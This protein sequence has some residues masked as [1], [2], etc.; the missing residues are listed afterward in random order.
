MNEL[1]ITV[2]CIQLSSAHVGLQDTTDY[3]KKQVF[4]AIYTFSSALQRGQK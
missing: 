3:K 1:F 4:D 2:S